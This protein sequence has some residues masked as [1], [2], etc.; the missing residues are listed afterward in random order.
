MYGD[1][2]AVPSAHHFWRSSE[3]GSYQWIRD[4]SIVL[5]A[6]EQGDEDI[7]IELAIPWT[8]LDIRPSPGLRIGIALNVSDNDRPGTAIQ[9]MMKSSSAIRTYYD[10]D[11]WGTL[12][13]QE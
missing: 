13:L 12:T 9:E 4:N 2:R 10:P 8:E 1:F 5:A 6:Q 3:G 7:T 11:T